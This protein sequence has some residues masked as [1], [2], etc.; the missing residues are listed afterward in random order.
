M[1]HIQQIYEL[2]HGSIRKPDYSGLSLGV[3]EQEIKDTFAIMNM[4]AV[5]SLKNL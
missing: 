3:T 2:Y 4:Q 1:R 5:N